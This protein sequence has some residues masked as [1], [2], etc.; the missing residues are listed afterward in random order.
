MTHTHAQITITGT[1]WD[2]Y[3][4]SSLPGV[5]AWVG[6]DLVE[7]VGLPEMIFLRSEVLAAE[8]RA[9]HMKDRLEDLICTLVCRTIYVN[10]PGPLFVESVPY[11]QLAGRI[12]EL[13]GQCTGEFVVELAYCEES[14]Q[15]FWRNDMDLCIDP[16]LPKYDQKYDR[17]RKGYRTAA[18][19][20]L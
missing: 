3:S 8:M 20:I 17:K 12:T 5:L 14:K 18:S 9:E 2:R 1:P 15:V 16:K 13:R 19:G 4:R 11:S 7:D 6:E 10:P